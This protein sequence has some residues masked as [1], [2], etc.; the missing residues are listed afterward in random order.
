MADI[1][2][3]TVCVFNMLN[4]NVQKCLKKCL[5]S[6][7]LSEVLITKMILTIQWQPCSSPAAPSPDSYPSRWL[8]NFT[9]PCPPF[10]LCSHPSTCSCTYSSVI[11]ETWL[12]SIQNTSIPKGGHTVNSIFSQCEVFFTEWPHWEIYCSHREMYVVRYSHCE[13][14]F[15]TVWS[16]CEIIFTLWAGTFTLWNRISQCEYCVVYHIVTVST[17]WKGSLHSVNNNNNTQYL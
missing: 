15:I 10:Q 17:L 14:L 6:V 16:H 4:Y 12:A 7:S 11:T 1:H 9:R 13:N 2:Y 8:G 5:H 3:L